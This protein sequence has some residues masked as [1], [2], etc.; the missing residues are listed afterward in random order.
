MK[1]KQILRHRLVLGLLLIAAAALFTWAQSVLAD[2]ADEDLPP[3]SFAD[4]FLPFAQERIYQ[5]PEDYELESSVPISSFPMIGLEDIVFIPPIPIAEPTPATVTTLTS[6]Y[7]QRLMSFDYLVSNIFLVDRYTALFPSDIDTEAFLRTDLRIDTTVTGP[8][9][10]IFHTHS[11]ERF[12]DSNPLNPMDS[13]VGVGR[14]L[15]E[16]LSNYGIE[17]L[18]YTAQ[19]DVVDG[20]PQRRGAYE[21]MEPVIQQVLADNP[22][23]QMVIDL[24]RDGVREGHGPFITYINGERMARIMFFNGLSRQYRGGQVTEVPW[25]PNPYQQENLNLSF[26]LQLAANELFPGFARRAYLREFR[27]SLHMMPMSMFVEVGNQYNTVDEAMRAMG[28]LAE[29]I[30]AVVLQGPSLQ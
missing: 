29:I 4:Y 15:A 7:I 13:V 12:V 21:R 24:H 2:S 28:P 23:I 9:V 5:E 25:L 26:R 18:H 8:Q 10:L 6:E 19:F 11:L 17:V 20:R 27:Y 22:S 1:K 30:A 3:S 14:H 16:L